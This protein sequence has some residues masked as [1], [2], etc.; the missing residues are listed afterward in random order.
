MKSTTT[1]LVNSVKHVGSRCSTSVKGGA[2]S[3]WN[4]VSKHAKKLI[5][6]AAVVGGSV[7]AYMKSERVNTAVKGLIASAQENASYYGKGA[8][9]GAYSAAHKVNNFFSENVGYEKAGLGFAAVAAGF[10]AYKSVQK[11]CSK[12]F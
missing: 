4:F 10:G 1:S 11:L 6:S 9:Y 12:C 5:A 2:S 7:A 3:A 8:Q